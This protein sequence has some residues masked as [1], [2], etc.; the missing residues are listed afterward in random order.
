MLRNH[1]WESVKRFAIWEYCV[2]NKGKAMAYQ[3][4]IGIECHVQL[5]T[6]TKLFAAVANDA[7]EAAPNTLI[8]HICVGMPGALPVLNERAIELASKMAFAFNTRP[9]HLSFFE[10]KHYF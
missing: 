3:V 7:R 6:T 2:T 8:S 5:N 1:S 10:R 4:T 9:Q